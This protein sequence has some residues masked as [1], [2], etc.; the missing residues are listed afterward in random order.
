MGTSD[1]G[2]GGKVEIAEVMGAGGQETRAQRRARAQQGLSDK[3]VQPTFSGWKY[4]QEDSFGQCE[5]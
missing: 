4:Q 2:A 5:N 1:F 3:N